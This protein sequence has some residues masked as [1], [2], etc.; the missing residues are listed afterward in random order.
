MPSA[1]ALAAKHGQRWTRARDVHPSR[2]GLQACVS[3]SLA[4]AEEDKCKHCGQWGEV[5]WG[6]AVENL[7]MCD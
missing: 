7:P 3:P 1:C 5:I 2:L 4:P 6:P